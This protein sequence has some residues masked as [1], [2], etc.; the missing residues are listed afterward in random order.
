MDKYYVI[1]DICVICGKTI[2]EGI[3]VCPLCMKQI[4]ERKLTGEDRIK[5]AKIT[6]KYKGSVK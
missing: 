2:P 1:K 5:K 4:M 3:M 6:T